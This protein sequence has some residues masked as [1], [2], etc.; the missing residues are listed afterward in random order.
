MAL[1]R[2]YKETVVARIQHDHKFAKAL[3]AE[4]VSA[5]LDGETAEGLSM[6]R[7]LVHAQ[8]TFK[9]LARQTG[10]GEKTLHRMLNRNG[11]PTARNLGVIVKYIAA[12]L[13]IKPRVE[14]A[15]C[16]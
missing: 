10:L 11:N 13:G 15:A 8:I 6:L 3:Y 1:T 7:D 2:D 9:E 4:A 12:D 5:L 14:L 16:S